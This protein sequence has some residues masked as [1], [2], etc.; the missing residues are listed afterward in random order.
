MENIAIENRDDEY[1]K[2]LLLDEGGY[3]DN[4]NDPVGETNY[5]V[6]K[7]YYPGLDIKN[8]NPKEAKQIHKIELGKTLHHFGVNRNISYKLSDVRTNAGPGISTEILQRAINDL[9]YSGDAPM[10]MFL[11][12]DGKLSK[13]GG[14]TKKRY[15]QVLQTYGEIPLMNAIIKHQ[16]QYY[17][18]EAFN[19][20]T[21]HPDLV[22]EFGEGW[23]N[24]AEYNPIIG[25]HTRHNWRQ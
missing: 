9:L 19:T 6:S 14:D 18:G 12:E 3:V 22:K 17:R 5:G 25:E 11:K 16:K 2:G 24:R 4:P 7:K 10:T 15:M 8:L 20:K 1:L 23:I 13:D 21:I